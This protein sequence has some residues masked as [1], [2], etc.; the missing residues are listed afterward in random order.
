MNGS[1]HGL[2]T[3]SFGSRKT[4]K[5]PLEPPK[6]T[7]PLPFSLLLCASLFP[8]LS[9]MNVA[10]SN[11]GLYLNI[12]DL[13]LIT[14]PKI[15]STHDGVTPSIYS[16]KQ[17]RVNTTQNTSAGCLNTNKSLIATCKA[18]TYAQRWSG[19][20]CADAERCVRINSW[21]RHKSRPISFPNDVML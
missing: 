16:N 15:V 10:H 8:S 21:K 6:H 17:Y 5:V 18:N 1:L 3:S 11:L 7:N 13:L 19:K 4:R 20:T 9:G 2:P 14:P 12:I